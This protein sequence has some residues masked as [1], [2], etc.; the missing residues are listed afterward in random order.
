VSTDR[1]LAEIVASTCDPGEDAVTFVRDLFGRLGEKWS[2]RTLD[3]LTHGPVRFTALMA[4]LPGISHRVLTVT[5]RTLES[6]G[7]I[8]RTSYPET[9]PRVEY[10]LTALGESFLATA[11]TMVAWA[12]DHQR[13]IENHRAAGRS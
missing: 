12:Q 10:A 6:D 8:S 7:M 9:P 11:M 5:L 1:T 2:M 4:A 3:E 13:E